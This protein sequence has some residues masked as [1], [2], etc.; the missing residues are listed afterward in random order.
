[1]FL[2]CTLT[3]AAGAEILKPLIFMLFHLLAT[4]STVRL[5]DGGT[6][7]LCISQIVDQLA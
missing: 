3:P 1:M 5:R 2:R 6:T 4:A 7:V